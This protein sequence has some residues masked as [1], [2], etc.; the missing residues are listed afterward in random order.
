M[1][2]SYASLFIMSGLPSNFIQILASYLILYLVV[3]TVYMHHL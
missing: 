2:I 3:F 1:I